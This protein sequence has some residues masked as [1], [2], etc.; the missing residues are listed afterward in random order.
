MTHSGWKGLELPP[1]LLSGEFIYLKNHS[2][3]NW[4]WFTSF[5]T[6][7]T[8]FF[9]IFHYFYYYDTILQV[10]TGLFDYTEKI[11]LYAVR[12]LS[13]KKNDI[14]SFDEI[15]IVVEKLGLLHKINMDQLFDKLWFFWNQTGQTFRW[16][17]LNWGTIE[18]CPLWR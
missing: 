17:T 5:A 6:I 9:K 15:A 2:E 12:K 1:S 13:L 16:R 11:W 18:A 8:F 4:G 10:C 14:P 3:K 7:S